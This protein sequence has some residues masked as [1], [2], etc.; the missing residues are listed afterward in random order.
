MIRFPIIS[1]AAAAVLFTSTASAQ[2]GL[3]LNEFVVTPTDGEMV[4][5]YNPTGKSIDLTD[6]YLTDAT[7]QGGGVAYYQLVD[8]VGGGGGSF[9]D[10]NSRF[11]AGSSIGPGEYQTV[12]LNGNTAF[13]TVY[14]V[15]PTYEIAEDD[16]LLPDVPDML[17]AVPGSINGVGN[18]GLTNGDEIVILYSWD[19]ASDLVTD[20]DY[21][22][23]GGNNE[24]VDKTGVTI[25]GPDG[26][27]IGSTYADDTAIGSQDDAPSPGG[28][29]SCG[30]ISNGEGTETIAGG[31]GENG[32]DETSENVSI[33]WAVGAPTPNARNDGQATMEIVPGTAGVPNTL[34]LAGAGAGDTIYLFITLDLG[35]IGLPPATCPGLALGVDFNAAGSQLFV[36]TAD[37]LGGRAFT[38]TP[39]TTALDVFVQAATVGASCNVTSV[40]V[41][42]GI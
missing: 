25:D 23:Y 7:F 39:V 35:S 11:P 20:L 3:L 33:T 6:V 21:V 26:D 42:D 34:T 16:G 18:G 37:G 41:I 17:E 38:A 5:I 12:A 2:Q 22:G 36:R 29:S 40:A 10:F 27:A 28:G 30:R 15:Q 24:Q 32:H 19:G 31:N 1:A 14:G 9:G 13:F 8:G 4:E